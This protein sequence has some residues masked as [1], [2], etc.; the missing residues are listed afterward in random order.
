MKV[1]VNG[2]V[3]DL[4]YNTTSELDITRDVI[5]GYESF[6]HDEDGR[7]IMTEEQYDWWIDEIDKLTKIDDLLEELDLEDDDLD[8]FYKE[9]GSCDLEQQTDMQLAWLH[10]YQSN[11]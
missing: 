6:P 5:G 2:E 3:R 8:Q 1:I 4:E 11:Q 9:T 10:E 7:W